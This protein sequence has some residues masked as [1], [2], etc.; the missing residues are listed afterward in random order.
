MLVERPRHFLYLDEHNSFII[1]LRVFRIRAIFVLSFLPW[2]VIRRKENKTK[3]SDQP[4]EV[5]VLGQL[6]PNSIF[7]EHWALLGNVCWKDHRIE[8]EQKIERSLDRARVLNTCLCGEF[9]SQLG[10]HRGAL[11]C[12][13]KRFDFIILQRKLKTISILCSR[14]I[15]KSIPICL[16]EAPATVA[17]CGKVAPKTGWRTLEDVSIV[18]SNVL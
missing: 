5:R 8:I 16:F 7:G 14:Q 2:G 9:S 10:P 15:S 18:W 11:H 13:W 1:G 6:F 17:M 12:Q 4:Q 3:G